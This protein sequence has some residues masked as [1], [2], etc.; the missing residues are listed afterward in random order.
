MGS[1]ILR[2]PGD[3]ARDLQAPWLILL[4]WLF[5]GLFFVMAGMVTAELA[6]RFPRAGGEY[7]YLREAY[8]DFVAF[9]FGWSFTVFI[10]GAGAAAIAAAFGDFGRELF[11]IDEGWSGPL[12]AGAV[13]AVTAVNAAGLRAGAG[14]QN[15]L[16]GAKVAALFLLV[17]VG[18]VRGS[19]EIEFFS[20]P[21]RASGPAFLTLFAA[22]MLPAL[23]A[24]TGTTDPAKMAEEIKDVRRALPRALVG[25][26][27][28]VTALYLLVNL[29]LMRVVPVS[30][31]AGM[32]FVPGE[33]TRRVL[34]PSGRVAML[35]VGMLV[36][37][38][39][40]GA[41]V[42][43]T[44]RVTFALARDGLT[45]RFMAHMS[46]AQAPVP[47]LVVVAGFAVLL[48]LTRTFTEVLRVYFFASAI[49]YG[50]S[51]ASLIVFR[52]RKASFPANVYRCPAGI[53]QASILI[54]IQLALAAAIVVGSPKD[55]LYTALL[56][57]FFGLLYFVWRRVDR[58]T[59]A[60]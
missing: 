31:M 20:V 49:L 9:F 56:L 47:A 41:Q 58:S 15:A 59:P 50:L 28:A 26:A 19:A 8:G 57:G 6:S 37:L 42:L 51:Y 35:V 54:A 23:W 30:E 29:A 5:G 55:A 4:A 34:G 46:K 44:I 38:S 10:I 3:L 22:G 2:A 52:V 43:A 53:L 13:V 14:V 60:R 1:G 7:V 40:L 32:T 39:A 16:T 48:V 24:Y 33:A 18:L 36:C 11:G 21:P 45:F 17:A 27:V 12:A 25:S